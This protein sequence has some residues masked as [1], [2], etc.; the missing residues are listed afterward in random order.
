[1]KRR[2]WSVLLIVCMALSM[3]ACGNGNGTQG[4]SDKI[5]TVTIDGEKYVLTGDFQEVVGS[6]VG[7]G[8]KVLNHF[9]LNDV[10]D[11]NG[12]YAER[13]HAD[14]DEYVMAAERIAEWE[15]KDGTLL[16]KIFILR[17]QHMDF[18]SAQGITSTSIKSDVEKMKEY[19][20]SCHVLRNGS[21]TYVAMYLDG[22][23]VDFS[24]YEEEYAEWAESMETDGY[25]ALLHVNFECGNYLTN[26]GGFLTDDM[27]KSIESIEEAEALFEEKNVP[28]KEQ[29][30]FD[31]ASR[32]A[33]K[34]LEEEIISSYI[35]IRYEFAED[36]S[37]FMEYIEYYYDEDYQMDKFSK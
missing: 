10:Y 7:N 2:F 5:A 31:F 33:N 17:G 27:L 13:N 3:A 4:L 6:M 11:E 24:D 28:L 9:S 15:W 19:I 25:D 21:S 1:M 20:D 18:K 35:T 8:L 26:L 32:D 30:L 37:V 29:K 36:G 23:P 22:K 34:M 16:S 14:P 12:K